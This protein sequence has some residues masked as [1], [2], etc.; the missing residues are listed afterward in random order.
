MEDY[1][2]EISDTGEEIIVVI[3]P[4]KIKIGSQR[5]YNYIGSLTTPPCTENVVWI[6]ASEV[7]IFSNIYIEIKMTS[8]RNTV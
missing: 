8:S 2:E 7:I 3:D 6:V 1:L 5:Y 4:N